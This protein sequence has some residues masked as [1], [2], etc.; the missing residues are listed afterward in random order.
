MVSFQ[1]DFTLAARRDKAGILSTKLR[2]GIN[3][4]A[5]HG[6]KA[7]SH[8]PLPSCAS[9]SCSSPL[10]WRSR[11]RGMSGEPLTPER[12]KEIAI[13]LFVALSLVL[14][15][16]DFGKVTLNLSFQMYKA[17]KTTSFSR[18]VTQEECEADVKLHPA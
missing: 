16:C 13:E 12:R 7:Q 6:A 1:C 17:S 4:A 9:T 18:L 2:N 15:K 10:A 11:Q 3:A 14:C 5:D 8:D